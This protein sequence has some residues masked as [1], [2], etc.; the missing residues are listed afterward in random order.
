[1][2]W[3]PESAVCAECGYSWSLPVGDA[4]ALVA[5]LPSRIDGALDREADPAAARRP[6]APGVWSQS[7]YVWHLVDVMSIGT[8]RLWTIADDPASGLRCWDEK[9]LAE[10]RQYERQS[11]VVGR[12]ALRAAVDRWVDAAGAADPDAAT[13]HDGDGTMTAAAVIRRNAHEAVHHLLDISRQSAT[14]RRTSRIE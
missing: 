14:D 1:V 3:Q 8:E 4:I 2:R 12:R 10:V 7:A 11:P 6:P 13:V 5:A 9:A